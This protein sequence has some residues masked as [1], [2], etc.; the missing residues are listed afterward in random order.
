MQQIILM[1]PPGAGKT[2]VG[3]YLAKQVGL[4][5]IDTDRVI[6]ER[7]GRPISQI[8]LDE[9]EAGFRALEKA[10]VLE[11]L[12]NENC[13]IALG[14]G[15][16]LDAEVQEKVAGLSDVIFLDVSISNAAPRVGFN[17]ERPLLMGNP[18]QQW[19]QLMEQRRG[20]YQRLAKRVVSTD[21]RKPAEVATEIAGFVK[22]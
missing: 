1:G 18:R 14:G 5:L 6:E 17:K 4:P 15:S 20:I 9:G 16:I 2:T 22:P 3:K 12:E 11:T 10:V 8:F 13:V 19:L 7:D 21:N